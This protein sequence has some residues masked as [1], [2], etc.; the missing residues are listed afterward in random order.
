MEKLGRGRGVVEQ[1]RFCG[2]LRGV[3]DNK[4]GTLVRVVTLTLLGLEKDS[5]A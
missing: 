2:E 5:P 1:R 3:F 4:N